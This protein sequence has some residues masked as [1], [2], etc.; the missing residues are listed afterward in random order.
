MPSHDFA[1]SFLLTPQLPIFAAT[2]ITCTLPFKWPLAAASTHCNFDFPQNPILRLYHSSPFA[3]VQS[4]K[5]VLDTESYNFYKKYA[6][7]ELWTVL[8]ESRGSQPSVYFLVTFSYK[9]KSNR[10]RPRGFLGSLW[11]AAKSNRRTFSFNYFSYKRKSN[12]KTARTGLNTQTGAHQNQN[13]FSTFL[14]RKAD[15]FKG[16]EPL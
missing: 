8:R 5:A 14:G 9:R 13:Y 3:P 4:L 7:V 10:N 6:C 16:K 2:K 15:E 1:L 11:H 12:I